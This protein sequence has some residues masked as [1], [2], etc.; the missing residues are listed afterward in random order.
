MFKDRK[1]AASILAEKLSKYK[2]AEGVIIAIPR[3]GVVLGY[4]LSKALNLPLEVMLTQKIG[5]P[6]NK[7]YS[8]GS[9]SLFG[10]IIDERFGVPQDYLKSEIEKA[11]NIL[12]LRHNL[13][14]S[15]RKPFTLKNKTV[16]VVDDGIATGN[17]I[18]SIINLLKEGKPAKII[19]A[20]PVASKNAIE[21][22]K[23]NSD[24]LV[25]CLIVPSEFYA[26]S[27]VYENFEQV[28]DDEV[29][30]MLMEANKNFKTKSSWKKSYTKRR[31]NSESTANY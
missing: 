24:V 25:Y 14:M 23:N 12:R 17:T 22:I 30:R 10:E 5:H 19:V 29:I 3:G 6:Y 1:H 8:I 16:I 26:V 28:S 13:Y 27:Q 4:E 2:D 9:V 20:V 7:E 21:K 15:G 18:L 31:L 11:R